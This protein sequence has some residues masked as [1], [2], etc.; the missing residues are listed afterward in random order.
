MT[1]H[2]FK[3]SRIEHTAGIGANLFPTI[4]NTKTYEQ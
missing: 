1:K 2:Y 4:N 3:T